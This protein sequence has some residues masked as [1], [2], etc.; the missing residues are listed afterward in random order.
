[1]SWRRYLAKLS[2]RFHRQRP[3]D[4]LEAE[5]RTH[6]EMEAQENLESGMAAEDAH[7]AALRRFGNVALVQE[8]SREMWG[9]NAL[10]AW[11]RDIRFGLRALGR[12]P[13]FTAVV[14]LSLALG[15]GANTAIFSLIDAVMLKSLPVRDPQQL[16]LL[17]WTVQGTPGQMPAG[18]VM[19]SF[20]GS[21]EQDRTGRTVGSSFSYPTFTLMQ[22]RGEEFSHLFAFVYA[23]RFNL[24]AGGQAQLV[25]G[26]L[27]SGGYFSGLG[28]STAVGRPIM[29]TDDR[30]GAA[31]VAVISYGYWQRR[32]GG[33]A[34]RVGEGI[35]IN[36]ISVTIV[37]VC[38]P[39]FFGVQAGR[40]IDVWLPLHTQPQIEPDWSENG[41]SI[42][43]RPDD[44]W[45][46]IMGRVKP[47]AD[48]PRARAGLEVSLQQSIGLP[49]DSTEKAS[50]RAK[51]AEPPLATGKQAMPVVDLVSASKGLDELRRS[52]SKPL[53]ILMVVVGLVLLIAC[54]NAANLLLARATVRRKEI[55]VRLA[56]GAGRRSLI[57]QL[58]TESVMLALLAGG[59]GILL[60]YWT[61]SLLLKFLSS[62]P[63][64]LNLVVSPDFH[65]LAF[66][67]AVSVLTGLL[68]GLAP[69]LRTTRVDLVTA[70]K[71]TGSGASGATPHRRPGL[72]LG[73]ALVVSQVAM[74]LLLVVGAGL[75]V[76]TLRNLE[77]VNLGFNR[78]NVLLFG[79][80]PTQDGYKGERLAGL[81]QELQSRIEAL[82]GVRSASL[83]GS[84][85]VGGGVSISGITLP[86]D[87]P[88]SAEGSASRQVYFNSVGP[89]FFETMGVPLVLGRKI[90]ERDTSTAPKVAVINEALAHKYF[91]TSN[92]VGQRIAAGD[93]KKFDT[94]I[95]GV[96]GDTKYAQVREEVPPT[97]YYPYLQNLEG[98]RLMHFEVRTAGDPKLMIPAV[99]HIVQSMDKNLPLFDVKTQVE[100][101]DQTLFQERLF[102]KLS[103]F[104]GLLALVL[105]CVG[106]YGIMAY[107][108]TRRTHE[109]GIRMA[110]GAR[111]TA[112]FG[113]VVR[114]A[115]VLAGIGMMIG[116]P[117]ALAAGRVIASLLYG[118]RAADPLTLGGAAL[119][120]MAVTALAAYLPA[121]RASNVDPM[122]A[123]RYE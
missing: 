27:V 52:S 122:V 46:V 81:Y 57:R 32:F 82:P 19:H 89:Q 44:W 42:F 62:G 111:R 77:N 120:M 17:R 63:E 7:Y 14:V 4:D 99:R 61:T 115:L 26:Q 116:I 79:I 56:I 65:V 6:L 31:P 51:S 108:V 67:A 37:G 68:F 85:L 94:E 41:R 103:G 98:V 110:L 54:A 45:L 8:R 114:D 50:P 24:N 69:A 9:W 66:T 55:S 13:G 23:D 106:L 95:V 84:T 60:A 100:Q 117:A 12:S 90:E 21:M 11:L 53:F 22:A 92:P 113:R 78:Q 10:E 107:E 30:A 58:L 43:L 93:S 64:T 70:L 76:R 71:E 74:S 39:E 109:I 83:S 5:I 35:S 123:L 48:D 38:P 102:A 36:N 97:I 47:G 18:D 91:G 88:K 118:L 34:S 121:R 75:F 72:G 59:M 87:A 104:F 16:R 1:M 96:V 49:H 112:V 28:V 101:I 86:G 25:D 15:I 2:A 20:Q 33:K 119:L 80:D 3:G 105:A 29:E 40:S 73:K